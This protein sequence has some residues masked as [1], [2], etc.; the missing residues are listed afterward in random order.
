MN[1]FA[2]L[3]LAVVVTSPWNRPS[4]ALRALPACRGHPMSQEDEP[5]GPLP[6]VSETAA[7][8]S[9]RSFRSHTRLTSTSWRGS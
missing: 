7:L 8:S 9:D 5:A 3:N 4:L 1:R 2:R 6:G